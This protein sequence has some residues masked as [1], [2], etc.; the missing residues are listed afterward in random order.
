LISKLNKELEES[1]QL[2]DSLKQQ[3]VESRDE[4]A[5]KAVEAH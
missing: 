3:L 1:H 2:I 4:L 5:R